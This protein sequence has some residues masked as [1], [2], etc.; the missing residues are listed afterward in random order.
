MAE[1]VAL[2][3]SNIVLTSQWLVFEMFAYNVGNTVKQQQRIK[4]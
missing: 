1:L 3:I 4:S 2:I